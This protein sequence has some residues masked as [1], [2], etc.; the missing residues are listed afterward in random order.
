[1]FVDCC[2]RTTAPRQQQRSGSAGSGIST[3]STRAALLVLLLIIHPSR[4]H[5]YSEPTQRT[6]NN[7]TPYI[8]TCIHTGRC[9]ILAERFLHY[10][11]APPPLFNCAMFFM[12]LYDCASLR[13]VQHYTW[14]CNCVPTRPRSRRHISACDSTGAGAR[15]YLF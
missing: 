15:C 7:D 4:S 14:R 13:L 3:S 2:T 8:H 11:C 9:F 6:A 10:C 12:V 5:G 1:M